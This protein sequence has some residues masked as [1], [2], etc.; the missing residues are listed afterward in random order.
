[1]LCALKEFDL[2]IGG[3]HDAWMLA[4]RAWPKERA[5][6]GR[7][8]LA[9]LADRAPTGRRHGVDCWHASPSDPINEF[10][11][12][13][14]AARE[15]PRRVPRSI[16]LVGHTHEPVM[17]WSDGHAGRGAVP[18]PGRPYLLGDA[19][20]VFADPGTVCGNDVDP[21]SWW[22]DLDTVRRALT[23]HRVSSSGGAA[24]AS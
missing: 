11:N 17:F 22:R 4:G 5:A 21:A 12:L 18:E 20:A 8:R 10:L 19:N 16:G 3:D 6:L 13:H 23:W 14:V 1:M 9:W 2:V 15:L 24:Y 7:R